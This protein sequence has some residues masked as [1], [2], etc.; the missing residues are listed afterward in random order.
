MLLFLEQSSTA[1][2]LKDHP[3]HPFQSLVCIRFMNLKDHAA[4]LRAV[5]YSFRSKRSSHSSLSITCVHKIASL[6]GLCSSRILG[7]LFNSGCS[8]HSSSLSSQ[9]GP[10]N[11][12]PSNIL[13]ILAPLLPKSETFSLEGQNFHCILISL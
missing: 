2:A 7:L 4:V 6:I 1:F 9:S 3:T 5:Q 12:F 13:S 8:G 11:Y 10:S